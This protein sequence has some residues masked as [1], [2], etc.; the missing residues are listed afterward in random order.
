LPVG[1]GRGEEDEEGYERE[2]ERGMRE[3]CVTGVVLD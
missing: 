3:V 1:E 2:C